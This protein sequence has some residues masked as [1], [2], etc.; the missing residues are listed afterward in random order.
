MQNF[1]WLAMQICAFVQTRQIL[2][3]K[4]KKA[5]L[6]KTTFFQRIFQFL[7]ISLNIQIKHN[8]LRTVKK[9]F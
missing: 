3:Q 1:S 6:S 2:P 8:I 5:L 7:T 4:H 9:K